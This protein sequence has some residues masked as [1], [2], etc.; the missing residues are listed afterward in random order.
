MGVDGLKVE[1]WKVNVWV[2]ES[3]NTKYV[4]RHT[5]YELRNINDG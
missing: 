4:V 1:G 3:R 5:H 2:W